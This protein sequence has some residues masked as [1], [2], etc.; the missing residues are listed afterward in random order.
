MQEREV[1]AKHQQLISG[2]SVLS[3]W[4]STYIWDFLSFLFPFSIAIV[5]FNIFGLDQFIGTGRLLPTIIMFLEYGLAVASSTYCLTFFFSDHTMAQNVVLLINFFTG[6]ILM[7]ISFIMG[8]IKSTTS[9]NSFLKNFLRLFPGFCFADGL[10]SLALLR[11]G[12]KDKT[13]DA[14]FDWNVTGASICYLGVESIC[15][16]LLT[17]AIEITPSCKLTLATLK[18]RWSSKSSQLDTSPHLEALLRS[19]SEDAALDFDEDIDVMTERNRVLSG[20]CE[21]AIIYLRNL[22]K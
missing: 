6:L 15:Y 13:S 1:K 4:A 8:L 16:F 5:L 21:K 2:V 11:Q 20:S 9:A 19:S 22:R 18:E 14:A 3:Y 12:M 10:A 7:V 17:L